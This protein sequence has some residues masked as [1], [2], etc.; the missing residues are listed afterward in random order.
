MKNLRKSLRKNF[1]ILKILKKFV[2]K[3]VKKFAFDSKIFATL[4][5]GRIS[6]GHGKK[7]TEMVDLES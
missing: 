6:H 1:E 4:F 5:L 2:K 7:I 3:F